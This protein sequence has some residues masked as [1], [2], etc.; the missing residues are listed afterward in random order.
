MGVEQGRRASPGTPEGARSRY[1]KPPVPRMGSPHLLHR[2]G[3]SGVHIHTVNESLN[4]TGL[5]SNRLAQ[6]GHLRV[7]A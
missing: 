3:A 2:D 5:Y 6:F 1:T 4:L 7:I